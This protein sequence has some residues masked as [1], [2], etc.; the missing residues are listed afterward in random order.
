MRCDEIFGKGMMKNDKSPKMSCFLQIAAEIW[1]FL[2]PVISL[3]S[4]L[5][6][7]WVLQLGP[8]AKLEGFVWR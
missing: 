1:T 7:L 4:L 3:Q 2:G 5:I 8:N 6:L